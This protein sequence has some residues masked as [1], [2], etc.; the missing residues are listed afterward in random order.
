MR[1]VARLCDG[2]T[3]PGKHPAWLHNN[4]HAQNQYAN[5]A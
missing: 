3:T 2:I 4:Q 5:W 1:A